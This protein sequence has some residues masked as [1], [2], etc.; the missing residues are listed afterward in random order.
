MMREV[1]DG[2]EKQKEAQRKL[3]KPASKAPKAASVKKV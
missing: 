2:V 3:K 1:V